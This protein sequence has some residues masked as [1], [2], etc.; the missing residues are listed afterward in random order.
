MTKKYSKVAKKLVILGFAGVML[1][2]ILTGCTQKDIANA[3]ENIDSAMTSVLN[4]DEI[5]EAEDSVFDK[6]TF[7]GADIEKAEDSKLA[8]EINGIANYSESDKKAYT[9]FN[10]LVSDSYFSEADSRKN[11]ASI[12]N[13]LADI[14]KNENY[15][16]YSITNVSNLESLNDSMGKATESPVEGFKVE[17][18]FLYGVSNVQFSDEENVVSF[19][20]KELTKFYRTRLET[21][22]GITGYTDGKPKFGMVTKSVTDHETFFIDNNVYLKLT[23]EEMAQAKS[24]E[25]LVFEKFAEY[26]KGGNTGKYVIQQT[27]ISSQKELNANMKGYVNF[28]DLQ[29]GK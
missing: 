6:F 7:L 17:N 19:S 22:Y 24:N 11:E 16:D 20:T 8:V 9:V 2:G 18:N 23:P 15:S 3:Q 26:V 14:V 25:S 4:L 29:N 12:I 13:T 5:K 1:T 28:T 21:S 10:Y 27:N